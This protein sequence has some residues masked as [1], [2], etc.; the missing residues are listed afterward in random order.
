VYREF[1]AAGAAPTVGQAMDFEFLQGMEN[2]IAKFPGGKGTL[3]HFFKKQQ[4]DI[5]AF[6]QTGVSGEAA[7]RAIQS[8]I[9]GQKSLTRPPQ[10]GFLQR[11]AEQW[12][13]LDSQLS[14]LINPQADIVPSNTMQTLQKLTGRVNEPAINEV[15]QNP[16]VARMLEAVQTAAPGTPAGPGRLSYQTLAEMR[17]NIGQRLERSALTETLGKGELKALYRAL[18]EDIRGIVQGYGKRA[19]NLYN[20]RQNL[21]EGRQDRV[22]K[23]LEKVAGPGKTPEDSWQAFVPKNSEEVARV[24]GVM[25]SLQPDE[26]QIVSEAMIA[27]MGRAPTGKQDPTGEKFSTENFLSNWV[28]M[29]DGAKQILFTDP[30]TRNYL[31]SVAGVS[32][33][34][35]EAG[36]VGSRLAESAAAAP[37]GLAILALMQHFALAT[38]APLTAFQGAK[39]LTNQNFVKWLSGMEGVQPSAIPGRMVR[40]SQI[41]QQ[42]RDPETREALSAYVKG[43]NEAQGEP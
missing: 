15:L 1:Q 30:G 16:T 35:R 5:G 31:N 28:S 38:L 29:S 43:L 14:K 33:R 9:E 26:R 42:S 27:R 2:L 10:G 25:R 12:Q 19:E 32:G 8:G 22:E 7:G 18:S 39:L 4:E 41:Y 3:R 24:R 34:L 6:T 20:H 17:E 13:N 36:K 37:Y 23:I 21:W 11:T 40:L